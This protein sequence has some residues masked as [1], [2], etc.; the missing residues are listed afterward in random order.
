MNKFTK[1]ATLALSVA[2]AAL[3]AH[4]FDSASAA[5]TALHHPLR[6]TQRR[7]ALRRRF[8]ST[9]SPTLDH[10][11]WTASA[12][13]KLNGPRKVS[14]SHRR[15]DSAIARGEIPSRGLRSPC[16][17]PSL[18]SLACEESNLMSANV[19]DDLKIIAQFLAARE[20]KPDR[21]MDYTKPAFQLRRDLKTRTSNGA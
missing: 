1:I 7:L 12:R 16:R 18:G 17:E 19:P 20:G 21:W 9:S 4:A 5:A 15:S 6:E 3:P 10:V 2:T 14:S 11:W 8:A 13:P